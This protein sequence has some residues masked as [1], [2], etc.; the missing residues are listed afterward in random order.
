DPVVEVARAGVPAAAGVVRAGEVGRRRR[1]EAGPRALAVAGEPVAADAAVEEDLLA[2]Q[3]VPL[4]DRQRV[5]G[6]PVAAVDLREVRRLRE[7]GARRHEL[8]VGQGLDDR[9]VG[10][11]EA[12]VG[13]RETLVGQDDVFGVDLAGVRSEEHT[14]ELQSLAYLVCRLLLEKK[15]KS[16]CCFCLRA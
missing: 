16:T 10:A 7:L 12:A 4:G 13:G 5:A 8:R 3:E 9:L 11:L 6:E 15:T 1:E 14:S 2:A